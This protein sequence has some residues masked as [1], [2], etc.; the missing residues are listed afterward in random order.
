M[1]KS[2]ALELVRSLRDRL[3]EFPK[4]A[5]K[6]DLQALQ[7]LLVERDDTQQTIETTEE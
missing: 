2:T 4:V 5:S 6:K 7:V 1:D 3:R